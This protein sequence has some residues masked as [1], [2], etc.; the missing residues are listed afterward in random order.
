M[1]VYIDKSFERSGE[2]W[3][4]RFLRIIEQSDVLQFYWSKAARESFNVKKEWQHAL[5]LVGQKG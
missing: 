1:K 4:K 3:R 5:Y 2:K